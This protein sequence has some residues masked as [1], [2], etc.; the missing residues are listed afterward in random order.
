MKNYN[1]SVIW[2]PLDWHSL[3]EQVNVYNSWEGCLTLLNEGALFPGT[4]ETL[5][6]TMIV[7]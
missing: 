2:E 1:P 7:A 4:G 3:E 6:Q 5:K